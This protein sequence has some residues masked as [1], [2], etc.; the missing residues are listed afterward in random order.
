MHN[1]LQCKQNTVILTNLGDLIVQSIKL[2]SKLLF[3]LLGVTQ[4]QE[5]RI[6]DL[7]CG[8][9]IIS[10]QYSSKALNTEQIVL[11]NQQGHYESHIQS[12]HETQ[13]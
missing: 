6:V 13:T 12:H 10:R 7:P 4:W 9:H 1:A 11:P 5:L 8:K 2:M 3:L